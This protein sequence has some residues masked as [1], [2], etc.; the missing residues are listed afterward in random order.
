MCIYVQDIMQYR[1]EITHMYVYVYTLC[2]YL[3][4][5]NVYLLVRCII[6]YPTVYI[7]IIYIPYICIY[8]YGLG[9][10]LWI[11]TTGLQD[12]PE[13]EFEMEGSLLL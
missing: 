6:C 2:V 5:Y 9:A 13:L 7:Y 4:I 11:W 1:K 3:H 8:M 10:L 12:S